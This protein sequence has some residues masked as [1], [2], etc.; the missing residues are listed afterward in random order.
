[1]TRSLAQGEAALAR[2]SSP[3][4]RFVEEFEQRGSRDT[5][6]TL[7]EAG[8]LLDRFETEAARQAVPKPARKPARYALGVWLDQL[9]RSTPGLSLRDWST[10][11]P[12]LLFDG[13]DVSVAR[14]REFQATAQ[15]EGG[16]FA[17][18]AAFLADV[19]ARIDAGRSA[20]L[21]Q[22]KE[23]WG[24]RIA[25]FA[26]VLIL[27]LA[28]YAVILEY[29]F[30]A[31]LIGAFELEAREIGLTP[32][33]PAT[34]PVAQL[35]ALAAAVDRV[36]EAAES[37]PWRRSLRLPVGDS[38]ATAEAAYLA[39]VAAHVPRALAEGIE[40]VMA[41]EGDGLILYDAL[42]AWAV[43]GG[44][45]PWSRGYLVGWL[46]DNGA[47]AGV[48]GL[49]RHAVH[50]DGPLPELLPQDQIVLDLA[51]DFAAEVPEADRAW[52]ELWRAEASRD[53]APWVPGD[54]VPGVG[55]VLNRRS[56][57]PIGTPLP[58]LFTA[59][60]WAYARDFGAGVAVQTARQLAPTV[61][62][63]TLTPDRAA[64]D[65]L[66]ERLLD[67]TLRAWQDWLADLRVRPFAERD[68]A[69]AVSGALAQPGSPLERL[70][71]EVWVQAG[72]SDR[73]RSHPMQLKVGRVFGPMIQ[74]VE[75][76]R[77]AEMALLF[78]QL[79]VALAAV[80]RDRSRGERLMTL[81]D[82]AR[83]IAA[84]K[85]APRIVVQIAEDV[86]VQSAGARSDQGAGDPLTRQWQSVVFP[87][88][89]STLRGHYPFAEGGDAGTGEVAAL[90]GPAGSLTAFL[91]DNALPL[92][93]TEVSPWRWK[94]EARFEGLT[95]E[96]ALFL[97]RAAQVSEGLFGADGTL[98]HRVTLAA[99]AERGQT[100]VS[101][102]GT[103]HPVRATGA[104]AQFTWPGPQPQLGVEVSF[105]EGAAPGRIV[106][107]GPWGLFRLTDGMRVRMRDEGQ[108][109]LLD[110]RSETGRVF[111]EMAFEDRFNPLS[112]RAALRGLACPPAL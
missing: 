4:F 30:H 108:R 103:A 20:T 57:T 94:P 98:S 27:A 74:Y 2:A 38:A 85:V 33:A 54:A 96:S 48:A 49:A 21:A 79:N 42:R 75:Q 8:A 84:L 77:M 44:E 53:L 106:H 17:P 65:L 52:L 71:A 25:G 100:L 109:A 99:L 101:I 61:T 89:V 90:L 105:R 51:R 107:A 72:G 55:D 50:L 68:A 58:G 60:G 31:P 12:R 34:D 73:S 83:S 92:L 91:R 16:D 7:R 70:L 28:A 5:L 43:L 13:R 87:Q 39:A 22:P 111:V 9:A 82:R 26:A 40:T 69:I 95:P 10:H 24:L 88:C 56:G 36:T 102:G 97:E 1:M 110:I 93:D 29:R 47:A 23:R 62:G 19:L 86:L 6:G 64:P 104:P 63:Y 46:E 41:T 59:A 112:V 11:A 15:R 35:D 18:L 81:S 37:A 45:L 3:V 14:V 32:D 78:S 76:G 80:E 66:M 67:E